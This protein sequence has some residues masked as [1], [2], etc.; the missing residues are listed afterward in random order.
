MDY[1]EIYKN[2]DDLEDCRI[3]IDLGD[4]GESVWGKVIGDGSYGINNHPLESNIHWQDI[5]DSKEVKNLDQIIHRRW[6]TKVWFSYEPAENEEDDLTRRELIFNASVKQEANVGFFLEGLGYMSFQ[7]EL[8][9][10]E[11]IRDKMEAI[12]TDAG[13]RLFPAGRK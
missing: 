8:K 13:V 6:K 12:I 7:E 11:E 3:H 1:K 10:S 5:V 4:G 9:T 2:W